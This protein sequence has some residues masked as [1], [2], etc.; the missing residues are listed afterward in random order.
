MNHFL[1]MSDKDARPIFKRRNMATVMTN[2]ERLLAYQERRRKHMEEM[3]RLNRDADA[4]A[5]SKATQE[6]GELV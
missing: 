5:G 2:R 6:L 1:P 4:A 3:N